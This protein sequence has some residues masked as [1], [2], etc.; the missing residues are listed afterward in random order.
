MARVFFLLRYIEQWGT[1]TLRMREL[2][3]EAGL[4]FP[5]FTETSHAFI[6]T[7]RT[8]KL[9]RE[10][11]AGLG[12]NPRQLAAVEYLQTHGQITTREYV[13]LTGMSARTATGELQDLVAKGLLT[14]LGQG[15]SR[16]YQLHQG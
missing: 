9:T 13:S 14:P 8:S 16:R 15:R 7:F 3:Q 11:L 1:G 6:V 5:E 10:Y 2:C 4:P 12:L